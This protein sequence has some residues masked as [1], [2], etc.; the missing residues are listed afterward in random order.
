MPPL[1]LDKLAHIKKLGKA[2]KL[3]QEKSKSETSSCYKSNVI[4][5]VSSAVIMH[6]IK[7]NYAAI[8]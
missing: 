2:L 6:A 8:V 1:Q 4:I 7:A 5:L 3:L